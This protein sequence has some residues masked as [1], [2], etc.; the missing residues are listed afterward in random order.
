MT[1]AHIKLAPDLRRALDKLPKPNG[2]PE[3]SVTIEVSADDRPSTEATP[4]SHTVRIAATIGVGQ[5][6]D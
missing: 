1:A 4:R 3:V 6:P 2:V 5:K